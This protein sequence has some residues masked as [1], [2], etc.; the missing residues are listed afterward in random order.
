M[1]RRLL[2]LCLAL[3]LLPSLAVSALWDETLSRVVDEAELLTEA[4][5]QELSETIAQI[6]QAWEMDVVILTV[7]TLNGKNPEAFADDYYDEH[8][9]GCGPDYSGVLLLLSMEERDLWLSTCGDAVYAIT[10]YGIDTLTGEIVGDLSDGNYFEAFSIYLE[11]LPDYFADYADGTPLDGA[12]S[13]DDYIYGSYED[14]VYYDSGSFSLSRLLIALVIGL[15]AGLIVLLIMRGQ[16]N[17]GRAQRS[18]AAYLRE[19]SYHLQ[20]HQDLFLYSNV[21]KTARPKDTDHG[22]GG[23]SIHR[24]SGGRSHGGGGRKF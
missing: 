17:T 22:G 7:D 5:E 18:A 21:T 14:T 6:T 8:L 2:C 13:A 20:V 23:S 10:D 9:Y 12:I 24:G 19:G 4:Q 16:M 11:L 15:A 3:L 1:K